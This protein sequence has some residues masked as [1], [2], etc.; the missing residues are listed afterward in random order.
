MKDSSD[1]MGADQKDWNTYSLQLT[2]NFHRAVRLY[3][4][5][6]IGMQRQNRL[7]RWLNKVADTWLRQRR[8][9]IL[10]VIADSNHIVSGTK[11]KNGIS[12]ARHQANHAMR[13][14]RD[15]NF[16]PHLIG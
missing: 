6:E 2:S 10:S 5:Y 11:R 15:N 3:A 4:D 8:G 13:V 12:Y 7:E 14:V 1:P 16:A 9:R